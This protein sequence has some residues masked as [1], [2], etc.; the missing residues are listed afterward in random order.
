MLQF[1]PVNSEKVNEKVVRSNALI[2]VT[3]LLLVLFWPPAIWLVGLL[4]LDFFIR[5]F[6]GSAYSP[7]AQLSKG[8]V[9]TLGLKP[10]TVN[11]APKQFAARIGF[12]LSALAGLFFL[13]GLSTLG[14]AVAGIIL[15]FAFAEGALGF[16]VA[17]LIY[18]YV[19]RLQETWT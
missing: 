10:Q 13:L 6:V 5:G 15:V 1:C 12:L 4:S 7:I 16:C 3:L 9:R 8:I 17:C 2:T 18:P 11:L 19:L 14:I